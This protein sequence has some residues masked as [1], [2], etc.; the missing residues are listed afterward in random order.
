MAWFETCASNNMARPDHHADVGF[1]YT[2]AMCDKHRRLDNTY[3]GQCTMERPCPFLIL[4]S[5]DVML[6]Q[7]IPSLFLV[8]SM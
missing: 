4:Q 2:R 5:C 7:N 3:Q 1:V 8:K 6:N